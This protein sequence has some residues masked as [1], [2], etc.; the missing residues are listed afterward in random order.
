MDKEEKIKIRFNKKHPL[1]VFTLLM[2]TLLSLSCTSTEGGDSSSVKAN[3]VQVDAK[4]DS[5]MYVTVLIYLNDGMET[6]FEEYKQKAGPIVKKHGAQIER[7]IK[8]VKLAQ[9]TM[10][11]P[12]EIHVASFD[13]PEGMTHMNED[14]EYLGLVKTL[15]DKAVRKLVFMICEPADFEFKREVGNKEKTFGM[16]LLNYNEGMKDQFDEYHKEACEIIPEFGAHFERFFNVAD[17]KGD[18]TRPD[19]VHLFYFDTPDGMKQMA[20]D[21][22]MLKLFPKRDAS[23]KSLNFIIGQAI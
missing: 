21:P 14:P 11:L 23:L 4:D 2:T 7:I 17:V 8:P 9:G 16:A 15:R 20:E 3:E 18:F 5:K 6:V 12:D 13:T 19:E 22:R 1:L 10:E